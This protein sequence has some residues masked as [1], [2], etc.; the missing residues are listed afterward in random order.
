MVVVIN[1][2]PW[3]KLEKVFAFLQVLGR[4]AYKNCEQS[5]DCISSLNGEG[6]IFS[7]SRRIHMSYWKTFFWEN[8]K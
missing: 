2:V 7:F 8:N 1:F 5:S 4:P 6:I 3:K